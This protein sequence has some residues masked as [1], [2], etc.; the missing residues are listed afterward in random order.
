VEQAADEPTEPAA[1]LPSD[2]ASADVVGDSCD[3]PLCHG[4]QAACEPAASEDVVY[5]STSLLSA[6]S[7]LLA[8]HP[9]QAV[10]S[11]LAPVLAGD[12]NTAMDPPEPSNAQAG[13]AGAYQQDSQPL[14]LTPPEA[15]AELHAAAEGVLAC[16]AVAELAVAATVGTGTSSTPQQ[17]S[18]VA[19]AHSGSWLLLPGDEEADVVVAGAATATA[20]DSLARPVALAAA[21]KGD[22]GAAVEAGAVQVF[23]TPASPIAANAAQ[24]SAGGTCG[25]EGSASGVTETGIGLARLVARFD[26]EASPAGGSAQEV[27]ETCLEADQRAAACI[28]PGRCAPQQRLCT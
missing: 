11:A 3:D 19:S 23:G 18:R 25:V 4:S 2:P 6:G 21:C 20:S 14:R 15:S 13:A 7:P 17:G 12:S 24:Y 28:E 8:G 5:A 27:E 16:S 22:A 1:A 26:L 10:A 9:R